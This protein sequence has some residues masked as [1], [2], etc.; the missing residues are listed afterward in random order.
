MAIS[1]EMKNSSGCSFCN[2]DLV[3][4]VKNSAK[5]KKLCVVNC[6]GQ[7]LLFYLLSVRLSVALL[8]NSWHDFFKMTGWI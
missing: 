6:R 4:H 2:L 3:F 1:N 8:C 5:F 7:Q